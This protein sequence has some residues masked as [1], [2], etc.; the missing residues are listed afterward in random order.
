MKT[1]RYLPDYVK[2]IKEVVTAHNI[3]I[4]DLYTEW[5]FHPEI[6][7]NVKNI[8]PTVCIPAKKDIKWFVRIYAFFKNSVMKLV[9]FY[10]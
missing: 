7:E 6:P 3:P 5:D 4:F 9:V 2:I 10:G 1:Q 8:F